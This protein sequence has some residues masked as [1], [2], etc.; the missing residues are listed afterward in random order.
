MK[1]KNRQLIADFET[2]VFEGQTKT[3]VWSAASIFTDLE[4]KPENVQVQTSMSSFLEYIFSFNE[5]LDIWFHNLKFDGSFLIYELLTG[6]Y[7]EYKEP[8]T[9][10]LK[11]ADKAMRQ[12][13]KAFTY[14]VSE[15]GQWYSIVISY[16]GF[17]YTFK[18]SLK[19]LPFD[20]ATIGE[21]FKTKYRK[22]E[23]DY[24]NHKHKD[25]EITKEEL[26]YIRNDVLVMHEAMNIMFNRG[27]NKSTI[28]SCCL[29][30]YKD[31]TFKSK[32][33]YRRIMPNLYEEP[34]PI[35][36]FLNADAYIRKSYHGGWCYVNP[37]KANRVL[38]NGCTYDANSHYS[39]QMHSMSGNRFPVGFPTWFF[40]SIPKMIINNK[41]YYYFVRIRCNF[42]LKPDMLPT[43][44]IKG[45]PLYPSN[46]WLTDSDYHYVDENG[47]EQIVSHYLDRDN[48]VEVKPTLTLTMTDFE[49]F[50]EHYDIENLEILDGCYFSTMAGIF[51]A[52]VDYWAEKKIKATG[53][54]RQI[55]KW[56]LNNLYGKTSASTN[57]AYKYFFIKDG[58]LHAK[59]VQAAEKDPGYIPIG[60]A[61]TSYCRNKTITYAQNNYQ[62]FCYSDTDSVHFDT[63]PDNITGI[64]IDDNKF[65]FW[66]CESIW[67]EAKFLK[68]K[69]YIEHAPGNKEEYIIRC[70]GLS[71]GPRKVLTKWLKTGK[72][73]DQP[74][75]INDFKSGLSIP[76]NL[77]AKTIEGGTILES[78]DFQ[79]G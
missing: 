30:N 26:D 6:D 51:D 69:T 1:K 72:R 60:S 19:L 70:A 62:Y 20:V 79:I 44:Q 12:I 46:K 57:S 66:K 29:S 8:D 42:Y 53:A 24:F 39:S 50:K 25:E 48:I 41:Q 74:F 52:Y 14:T 47:K 38:Y 3:E 11:K 28:G 67:T 49:L 5:D 65:T 71:F 13:H 9:I 31:I 33:Q 77:K 63:T 23:M 22:L 59:S 56:A 21:E 35:E 2:T 4:T 73:E 40:N 36:G 7:V 18:D 61:I 37:S 78:N 43:I 54:E 17:L 64:P 55:C 10:E 15:I 32:D 27:F 16:N 76:E 75:T 34:C 68:Q 58:E 45:D